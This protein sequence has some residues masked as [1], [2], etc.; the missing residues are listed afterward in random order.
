[1][2]GKEIKNVVGVRAGQA[3]QQFEVERHPFSRSF[4]NMQ[5]SDSCIASRSRGTRK[6]SF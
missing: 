2:T 1:M 3:A 4:N 5:W 6:V